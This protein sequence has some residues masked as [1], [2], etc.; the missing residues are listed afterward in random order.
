MMKLAEAVNRRHYEGIYC[1]VCE[2]QDNVVC[3][4]GSKVFHT[5]K[6]ICDSWTRENLQEMLNWYPTLVEG[7]IEL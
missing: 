1:Q 3:I 4:G 2:I 6:K 5:A 7:I